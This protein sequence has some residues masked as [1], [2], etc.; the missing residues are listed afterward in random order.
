MCV[1]LWVV[2]MGVVR[3]IAVQLAMVGV[4]TGTTFP[5]SMPSYGPCNGRPPMAAGSVS[6]GYHG[7]LLRNSTARDLRRAHLSHL[8]N[9]LTTWPLLQHIFVTEI[10]LSNYLQQLLRVACSPSSFMSPYCCKLCRAVPCCAVLHHC[11]VCR[12]D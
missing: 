11:Q 5:L 8:Q 9:S 1:S 3:A 10:R 6:V 4:A 12:P 2:G 7:Y